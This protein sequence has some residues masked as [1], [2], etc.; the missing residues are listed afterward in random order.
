MSSEENPREPG[1]SGG[2]PQSALSRRRKNIETIVWVIIPAAV[3]LA[4]AIVY[5]PR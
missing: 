5:W 2:E 3:V 4:L 1:S